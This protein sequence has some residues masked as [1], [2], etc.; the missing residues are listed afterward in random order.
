M[1]LEPGTQVTAHFKATAP[2]LL[3]HAKP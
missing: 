1:S 3:H 2:H